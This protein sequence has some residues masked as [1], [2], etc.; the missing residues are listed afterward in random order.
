MVTIPMR[1][2]KTFKVILEHKETQKLKFVT[3]AECVDMDDC[4]SHVH[5]T[6]GEFWIESIAEVAG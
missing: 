2:M 3:V 1:K 6:E 4:V 5:S